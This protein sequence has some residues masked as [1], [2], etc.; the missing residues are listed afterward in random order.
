MSSLLL[1]TVLDAHME[2]SFPREGLLLHL[3]WEMAA[4]R[5]KTPEDLV[6]Q[7]KSYQDVDDDLVRE[8]IRI[9]RYV[10]QWEFPEEPGLGAELPEATKCTL[11]QL[12]LSVRRAVGQLEHVRNMLVGVNVRLNLLAVDEAIEEALDLVINELASLQGACE[13]IGKG[14]SLPPSIPCSGAEGGPSWASPE[15]APASPYE[16]TLLA[17]EGRW[18]RLSASTAYADGIRKHASPPQLVPKRIKD[19]EEELSW[20]AAMEAAGEDVRVK[21]WSEDRDGEVEGDVSSA[22]FD[23]GPVS[24]DEVAFLAHLARWNDLDLSAAFSDQSRLHST[25]PHLVAEQLFREAK[26]HEIKALLRSAM[27]QACPR[28]DCLPPMPCRSKAGKAISIH[29]ARLAT[30]S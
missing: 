2:G 19:R 5:Y 15:G 24:P 29:R 17:S 8:I 7:I 18:N 30:M 13:E 14:T 6:A 9:G 23:G 1:Q 21:I 12:V 28:C 3:K 20:E 10:Q 27:E 25:S 26:R 11:P 4:A 22:S 16:I